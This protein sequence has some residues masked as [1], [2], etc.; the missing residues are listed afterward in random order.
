MTAPGP[1]SGATGTTVDAHLHLWR[2]S[3]GG[4]AWLRPEV[5]GVL[6]DDFTP[7][8]ARAELDAAGLD[9]AI[10]VQAADTLADT[11]FMLEVAAAQPWV[12]GVVG[13]V[14][15]DE[16]AAAA[17][18]LD[19]WQQ[20]PAFCGIRHLVHGDPRD[21]FLELPAVRESLAELARRELPF[22]V[23]DA[24]P[25]HLERTVEL[26]ELA[27][28]L[29]VVIDH[30]GKPP[31]DRDGRDD[32]LGLMR[33]AS[34]SPNVVVK[35][36]GLHVAGMPFDAATVRPLWEIALEAFGPSRMMYG[37]DWPMTLAGGGYP[38]TWRVM[39]ELI[40]ELTPVEATDVL[41]GTAR[42][43]YRR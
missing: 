18:A 38:V 34:R 40:D 14:P 13:W 1:D 3:T 43:V 17:R 6:V 26:A 24:W 22:D 5:H 9:Q 36:S 42:R 32:W 33:R 30:L 23:P 12:I 7:G 29:V 41:G 39:R 4:Y 37:G 27:P 15:L 21:A 2:A 11:R 31:L 19:E 8:Q 35:V 16:P 25:R 28:E 10:L 20:H